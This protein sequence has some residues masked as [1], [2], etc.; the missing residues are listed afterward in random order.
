VW[1]LSD[2]ECNLKY[3]WVKYGMIFEM[4]GGVSEPR[5]G[6][7]CGYLLRSDFEFN[8]KYLCL[9]SGMISE[10]WGGGLEPRGGGGIDT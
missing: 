7:R 3:V 6:W 1:V 9:N 4:C 8:L 5:G 2:F 10:M